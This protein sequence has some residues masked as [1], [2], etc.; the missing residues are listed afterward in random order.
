MPTTTIEFT[1]FLSSFVSIA[2]ATLRT[3]FFQRRKGRVMAGV[4]N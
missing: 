3:G 2:T 4:A 1:R